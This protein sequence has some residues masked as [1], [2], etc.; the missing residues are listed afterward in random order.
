MIRLLE[1]IRI[2]FGNKRRYLVVDMENSLRGIY[3]KGIH[4]LSTDNF[5]R[6]KGSVN[7]SVGVG[8]EHLSSHG[9]IS[10]YV[11]RARTLW[12]S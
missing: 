2:P 3:S 7:R 9:S 4:V 6:R 8:F 1:V 11:F 10:N 12:K 5:S